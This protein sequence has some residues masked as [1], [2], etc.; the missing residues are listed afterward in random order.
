MK[1]N[2]TTPVTG[3]HHF[4]KANA[5]GDTLFSVR[6]GVPLSD[7]L[8]HLTSLLSAAQ[9]GVENLALSDEPERVPGAAW[10]IY[11]LLEMAFELTQAIHRGIGN[12]EGATTHGAVVALSKVKG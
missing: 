6:E 10:G 9:A 5:N 2:Q 8:D 12:H 4:H 1:K 11:H 3:L 7:A